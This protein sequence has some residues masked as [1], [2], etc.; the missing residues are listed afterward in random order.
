MKSL[1]RSLAFC[2]V[3]AS[4]VVSMRPVQAQ[5]ANI[6]P[7]TTVDRLQ[8]RCDTVEATIR[9][10]HTTDS[11]LRVNTGQVYND[12]SA[13]LIAKLNGRL[14]INR[15]DSTELVEIANQFEQARAIFSSN[16]NSYEESIAS[17]TKINCKNNT[18]EYYAQLLEAREN[19]QKLAVSV[20]DLNNL[21]SD[22]RVAVEK[23]Q[24]DL[25]KNNQRDQ[26]D[27]TEVAQ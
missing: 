2:L 26:A 18:A 1:I 10:L 27:S 12:I 9:R 13:N 15:I 4:F 23:L 24:G 19:R 25:K 6:T 8:E 7:Q 21:V 5:E 3:I 11:L 14:A 20:E 17:L 22:Y 16:Y